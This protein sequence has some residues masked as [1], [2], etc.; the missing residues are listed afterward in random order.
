VLL[1][2]PGPGGLRGWRKWGARAVRS[3]TAVAPWMRVPGTVLG[4]GPEPEPAAL[5]RSW[6]A[7]NL[8]GAWR[9]PR[10]RDYLEALAA[11][12]VPLLAIAGAGDHFLAPPEA[13][14]DLLGRFGSVDRTLVVAGVE[15]GFREDYDHAGLVI[16][17][18]ARQEV[19]PLVLR[20]L[21][22]RAAVPGQEPRGASQLPPSGEGRDGTRDI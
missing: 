11:A 14:R 1:G 18:G 13:V 5:I 8:A 4:L 21:D 9:D 10:G 22:A 12:D 20:W 16:G 6:M 19:W 2:A 7:W 17:R 3:L 15:T